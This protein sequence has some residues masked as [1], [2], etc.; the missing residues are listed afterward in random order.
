MMLMMMVMTR[1]HLLYQLVSELVVEVC[2]PHVELIDYDNWATN[3]SVGDVGH[4]EAVN[5]KNDDYD[6]CYFEKTRVKNLLET[7]L[8]PLV[9][10]FFFEFQCVFSLA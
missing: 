1:V 8:L 3:Y 9:V 5:W 2:V 4:F 7:L 6:R 10:N